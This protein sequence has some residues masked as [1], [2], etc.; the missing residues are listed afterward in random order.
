[1]KIMFEIYD[2]NDCSEKLKPMDESDNY[3][4]QRIAVEKTMNLFKN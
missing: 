3:K 2:Q 4:C 1:M